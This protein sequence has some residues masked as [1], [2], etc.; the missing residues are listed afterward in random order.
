MSLD[1]HSN[2]ARWTLPVLFS[3][4]KFWLECSSFSFCIVKWIWLYIYPLFFTFFSHIGRCWVLS[5]VPCSVWSLSVVLFYRWEN[6]GW[7][8]WL[9]LFKVT[10]W[11]VASPN[12]QSQHPEQGGPEKGVGWGGNRPSRRTCCQGKGLWDCSSGLKHRKVLVFF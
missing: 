10:S 2:P 7:E 5:R 11:H 4:F 8:R 1:P 9:D 3:S 6:G 12:L